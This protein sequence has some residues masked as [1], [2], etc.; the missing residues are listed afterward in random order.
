MVGS[1][2]ESLWTPLRGI[3][4]VVLA[5]NLLV[6][7]RNESAAEIC[8][9]AI[10]EGSWRI[11]AKHTTDHQAS[12]GCHRPQPVRLR[13]NSSRAKFNGRCTM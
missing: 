7:E 12:I 8:G 11:E 10:K 2:R 13:M 6:N 1:G 4:R 9:I 3:V 5:S